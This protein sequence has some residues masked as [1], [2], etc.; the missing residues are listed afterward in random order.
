MTDK[1][2]ERMHKK[3]GLMNGYMDRQMM[4]GW[5]DGVETEGWIWYM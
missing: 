5:T 4:D 2:M 1:S 3:D